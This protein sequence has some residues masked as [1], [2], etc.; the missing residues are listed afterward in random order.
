MKIAIIGVGAIGGYIGTRLA[1]AGNDLTFIARG[2]SLEALRTR[3]IKLI[4]ANGS[5][6]VVPQVRATD[7]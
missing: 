2:A 4:G 1:L 3:G 6:E 7:D 5:E